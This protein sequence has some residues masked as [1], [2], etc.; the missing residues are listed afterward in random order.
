M[1]IK[2]YE[3]LEIEVE[4]FEN[5]DVITESDEGPLNKT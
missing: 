4:V 3:L 2:E 1:N 5:V